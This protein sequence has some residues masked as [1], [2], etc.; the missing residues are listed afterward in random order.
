M[1]FRRKGKALHEKT[2]EWSEWLASVD[3]LVSAAE[4]PSSVLDTEEAWLYYIDRTYSQ[5][6]YL[7]K[8]P[9]FTVDLLSHDQ[10]EAVWS[11]IGRWLKD[12]WPDAPEYMTRQLRATHDPNANRT[13]DPGREAGG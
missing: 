8:A 11:L 4:I 13:P 5:A 2:R 12:R 6:G 3:Q 1:S 7:G 9:W 10:A